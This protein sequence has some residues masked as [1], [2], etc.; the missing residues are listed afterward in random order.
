MTS[1][2]ARLSERS[3]LPVALCLSA[4]C[5]SFTEPDVVPTD[6][7][8]DGQLRVTLAVA[9][10]SIGRP[11]GVLATLT[12]ENLGSEEVALGTGVMCLAVADVF[13]GSGRIPFRATNYGCGQAGTTWRIE[14]HGELTREWLLPLTPLHRPGVYRF[15]VRV[16]TYPPWDLE[17][18]FSVR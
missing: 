11:S 9:P 8:V 3:L 12:L 14:G 6:G 15:V 16:P 7:F 18:T 13:L 4:S 2:I 17:A 10:R 1:S 5:T